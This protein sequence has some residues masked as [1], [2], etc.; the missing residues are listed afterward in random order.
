MVSFDRVNHDVLMDRLAKRIAD[1]A[2][3]RLTRR[4]LGAGI[5]SDG[6]VTENRFNVTGVVDRRQSSTSNT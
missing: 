1:K 6:V 2:V 3:L 4:Y 5:L